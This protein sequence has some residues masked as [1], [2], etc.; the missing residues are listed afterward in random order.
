MTAR[1]IAVVTGGAGFIGSHMVDLL[2]EQGYGVRVI[3]SL[4][5]G[6][7]DN[8]AAHLANENVV[9]DTRDI[10]ELGESDALFSGAKYVF[11]F[12]RDRRHRAVD[13]T[14]AW[15]YVGQCAGHGACPGSGTGGQG[16]A[17]DLCGFVVLLW[18]GANA[19]ARIPQGRSAI[20]LCAQQVSG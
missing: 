2:V 13:G 9:L 16:G 15:L 6:R 10:R 12:R 14:S 1:P 5:G 18:I 19:D 17:R 8:L 11:L 20:S 3:D 7:E 4:I